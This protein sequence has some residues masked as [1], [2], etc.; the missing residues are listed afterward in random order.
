MDELDISILRTIGFLPFGPHPKDP[1]VF[2]SSY[3]AEQVGTTARTVR[4]RLR[5]ME[6]D[7]LLQGYQVI[8]NFAHLGLEVEGHYFVSSVET[9]KDDA[10][11]S[12]LELPRMTAV[13]DFLG[14]GVCLEFGFS[15]PQERT[16]TLER[17]AEITGDQA[18]RP[19]YE[20]IMPDVTRELTHLDWRILSSLRW[21]A[22]KRL[23]EVAA[24]LDVSRRTVKRRY[25]RMADEGS[26][27]T[28]A[29]IDPG[30]VTGPFLFGLMFFFE[31]ARDRAAVD[32]ILEAYQ[33]RYLFYFR[34]ATPSLGHLGI[35]TF[36]S[37]PAEVASLRR[38]GEG[39][40]E[41]EQVEPQFYN[42][43]E[44]RSDWF[45]DAI[46]ARIEATAP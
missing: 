8:P 12:A 16:E 14:D 46:A 7:G 44:D 33:D 26:F 18:H 42:R 9:G 28:V 40:P 10:I 43:F 2:K 6:E 20:G 22:T 29:M 15:N 32:E 3:I 4:T 34:P 5:A 11:E 1:E 36:A 23:R 45:D 21:E 38:L 25:D 19:F 30:Q 27:V 39:F 31:S 17:L 35:I 24:E 41:V 37:T 13:H